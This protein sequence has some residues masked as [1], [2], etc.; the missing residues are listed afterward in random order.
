MDA[1]V[2]NQLSANPRQDRL[3]RR[4]EETHK[5]EQLKRLPADQLTG[6]LTKR[7][8]WRFAPSTG[9]ATSSKVAP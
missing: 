9:I 2:K 8:T 4:A 1:R 5:Y 3:H 7:M 6:K